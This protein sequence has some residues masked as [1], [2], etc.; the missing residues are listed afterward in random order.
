MRE[1]GEAFH[2]EPDQQKG[3]VKVS[4]LL[5]CYNDETPYISL[6]ETSRETAMLVWFEMAS[7]E[8]HT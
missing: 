2:A 8:D 5:S 4:K 6:V 3:Y 1:H 7:T